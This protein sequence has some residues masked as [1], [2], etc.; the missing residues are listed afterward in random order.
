MSKKNKLRKQKKDVQDDYDDIFD[1]K[2]PELPII[3]KK[4]NI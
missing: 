4:S 3:K 1:D 2:E